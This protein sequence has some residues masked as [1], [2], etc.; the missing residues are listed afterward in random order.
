MST[1]QRLGSLTEPSP[2]EQTQPSRQVSVETPLGNWQFDTRGAQ[3]S[4]VRLL[5][6]ASLREGDGIVHLLNEGASALEKRLVVGND[7]LELSQLTF[8]VQPA[9]GLR[10]TQPGETGEL[11]FVW[12]T[13]DSAAQITFV[14]GF[15]ADDYLISVR[16]EV[17]GLSRPLLLESLGSG[18]AFSEADSAQEAKSMAWVGNHVNEGIDAVELAKVSEPRLREGPFGWVGV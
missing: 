1:P 10:L 3:L 5:R 6:Y 17:K 12:S 15:D 13:P 14:Y 18:L 4:Q 8:D 2:E 16:S 7:T 11:T 9:A